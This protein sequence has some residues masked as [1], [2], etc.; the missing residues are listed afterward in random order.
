MNKITENDIQYK[1]DRISNN[2]YTIKGIIT[3]TEQIE[4][5]NAPNDQGEL[6]NLIQKKKKELN[7]KLLE[8]IY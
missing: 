4:M 6:F 2:S 3:V 1:L 5:N 8:K 7:K